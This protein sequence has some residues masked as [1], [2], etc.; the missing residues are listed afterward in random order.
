MRKVLLVTTSNDLPSV[1]RVASFI[2]QYGGTA[3]RLNTDLFPEHVTLTAENSAGNLHYFLR[4]N[5]ERTLLNDC[6]SLWYRRMG[7]GNSLRGT[8]EDKFFQPAVLESRKMLSGMLETLPCFQLNHYASHLR[9]EHKQLQLQLASLVGLRVPDTLITNDESAAT[10]FSRKHRQNGV[11]V[12]MQSSFAVMQEGQEMVV[13]TQS[14]GE[15]SPGDLEGIHLCPMM[16]QEKIQRKL[17]LRITIVGSKIFASSIEGTLLDGD[18]VDWRK[19]GHSLMDSWKAF[20][21]PASI[22]DKILHLMRLLKLNYG[23]MDIIITPEDEFVFLEVNPGGEFFWQEEMG[24]RHPI[25]E[26]IAK[27]LMTPPPVPF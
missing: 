14:L 8:M 15:I 4:E 12:K 9:A 6:D 18:T 1:E 2:Q 24:A 10:E 7:T 21:L 25:C 11:I 19:K 23:A 3:I 27:L 16:F 17:E 26:A 13:F 5:G 20:E 22:S